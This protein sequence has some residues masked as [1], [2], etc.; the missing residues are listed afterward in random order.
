MKIFI[1]YASE[2]RPIADELAVRLR[3]EG[4]TVFLDK[5]N[6][7]EGEGYDAQ[8]REAIATCDLYLFLVSPLSV[9]PGRY[10]MTELKFAREQ[11]PNP[12]G[13]VLPVMAKPTPFSDIPPYLSAITLLQP[14]GNLVA[15]TVAE[16][17]SLFSRWSRSR[18]LRIGGGAIAVALVLAGIGW[19]GTNHTPPPCRLSVLLLAQDASGLA[20]DVTTPAGTTALSL[21]NAPV[22]FEVGPFDRKDVSW[23]AMLRGRDGSPLGRHAIKG[24]PRSRVNVDFG[25]GYGLVIDPL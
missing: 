9:Q 5:D 10:T 12:R 8:I 24:C 16:V 25:G 7:P 23:S 18:W 21:G 6:L 2:E 13:R 1:S 22:P 4:H 15:E 14:Q 3:T 19:R 11:F 17:D 20:L